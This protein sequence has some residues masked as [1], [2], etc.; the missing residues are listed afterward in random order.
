MPKKPAPL[1][2][3]LPGL[4]GPITLRIE[5]NP[6]NGGREVLGLSDFLQRTL[7]LRKNLAPAVQ[8]ATLYHELFHFALWD[9]GQ[10]QRLDDELIEV[11]CDIVGSMRGSMG[12]TPL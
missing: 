2:S 10:H 5:D 3:T 4:G 9:A 7:T 12:D 8:A 11:L 1:P 6:T